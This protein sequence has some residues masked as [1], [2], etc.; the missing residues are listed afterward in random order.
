MNRRIRTRTQCRRHRGACRAAAAGGE[1]G[2]RRPVFDV[3]MPDGDGGA[4]P[5]AI[6]H[7]RLDFGPAAGELDVVGFPPLSLSEPSG[8]RNAA[9]AIE[10]FWGRRYGGTDGRRLYRDD[11]ET[12]LLAELCVAIGRSKSLGAV[13]E[14]ACLGP[15]ARRNVRLDAA[16]V[17]RLRQLVARRRPE[18]V[19]AELEGLLLGRDQLPATAEERRTFQAAFEDRIDRGLRLWAKGVDRGLS[20]WLAD[21]TADVHAIRRRGDDKQPGGRGLADLLGEL[22]ERADVRCPSCRARPNPDPEDLL[23]ARGRL[24][25]GYRCPACRGAFKNRFNGAAVRAAAAA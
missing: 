24:T 25:V 17:T 21:V 16:D 14:Q 15:N 10:L 13:Y 12:R 5:F 19:R 1:A 18:L 7:Q 11:C 22:T 8:R 23:P 6:T 2:H 4:L 20:L 9:S 3:W